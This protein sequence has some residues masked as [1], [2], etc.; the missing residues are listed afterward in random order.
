MRAPN[1]AHLFYLLA[2]LQCFGERWEVLEPFSALQRPG[3]FTLV[4]ARPYD[5][6]LLGCCGLLHSVSLLRI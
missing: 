4:G 5:M 2:L 3:G 1:G 6:A